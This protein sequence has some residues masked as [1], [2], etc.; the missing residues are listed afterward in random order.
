[1]KL[2]FFFISLYISAQTNT[3]D[4]EV[5]YTI[6]P[7]DFKV[8]EDTPQQIKDDMVKVIEFANNQ[9]FELKLN[10]EGSFFKLIEYNEAGID[11]QDN[12]F[13]NNMACARFTSGFMEYYFN[14]VEV[15]K[16]C[17]MLDGTILEL[18]PEIKNWEISTESKMIN[19]YLCYK[20]VY[21]LKHITRNGKE[22]NKMITAWFAPSLPYSYGPKEFSGLPGLILELQENETTYF[23]SKINLNVSKP[24]KI[25]FPDGKFMTL[26]EFEKNLDNSVFG[27]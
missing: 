7:I 6:N 25:N 20:A 27:K 16:Y 9:K 23:A 10:K 17:K 1:M 21:N 19:S 11:V 14:K 5:I 12:S 15:K 3:F 2:L 26:E 13:F 4:G 22:K 24:I 8:K 18:N